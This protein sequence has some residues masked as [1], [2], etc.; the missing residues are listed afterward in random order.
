M[1]RWQMGLAALLAVLGPVTGWSQ[2]PGA[3]DVEVEVVGDRGRALSEYPLRREDRPGVYKAY[4]EATRGQNYSLKIRNRTD[5]RIGVVVAVDGRNIISGGR[6]E[7]APEERMYILG[8]YQQE[9]YEGWRTGRNRINRFY[10]TD[11]GNSYS[12]AWGDYSAMGVIAVAAFREVRSAWDQGGPGFNN[13]RGMRVPP[14]ADAASAPQSRSRR[15]E[16]GTGYGESEWSP[17]RR[18]EFESERQP[19]A[20]FFLKYAWRDTLCRERVIDC[21]SVTPRPP[22]NRFWDEDTDRFA[23]PPPRRE[24]YETEDWR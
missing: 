16:P 5:Q 18:V 15:A 24:R 11:A 21:D 2:R 7:L 9:T 3:A 20:R 22:R 1:K 14:A 4:L 19:F 8:P 12:G 6:S 10:F 13:Q 23:P 17:S